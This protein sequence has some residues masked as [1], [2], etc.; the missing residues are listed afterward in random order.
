VSP[1]LGVAFELSAVPMILVD[2]SLRIVSANPASLRLLAAEELVGRLM[3][4]FVAPTSRYGQPSSGDCQ[5]T[6]RH[7]IPRPVTAGVRVPS[8]CVTLSGN[9]V[10]PC[11]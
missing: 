6:V 1:L 2:D 7:W 10:T 8:S 5:P 4:E 11:A 9:Y 3:V